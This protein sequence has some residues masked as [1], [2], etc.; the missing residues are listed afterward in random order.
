[1]SV[2]FKVP[3]IGNK[4]EKQKGPTCWFYAAKMIRKFHDAYDKMDGGSNIR[5]LSLVR[6]VITFMDEDLK[7]DEYGPQAPKSFQGMSAM[8][9]LPFT[10]PSD[11]FG[12]VL[13]RGFVRFAERS[14][15]SSATTPASPPVVIDLT[16]DTTD[17]LATGTATSVP[18]GP[19]TPNDYEAAFNL[20]LTWG[21]DSAFSRQAILDKWD[22]RPLKNLQI[23][24]ALQSPQEFEKLL[25][26]RGPI[27]AGG[28]FEPQTL[29]PL[30]PGTKQPF[31][32]GDKGGWARQFQL[33]T[34][35]ANTHAIAV[36]GVSD[37]QQLVL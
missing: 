31:V 26:E 19:P 2:F 24:N 28:F 11:P 7:S 21:R 6:K 25:I 32:H 29:L 15:P 35:F 1:M 22:F 34:D 10:E 3:S 17:P 20:M 37:K 14:T 5:L 33:K 4:S 27:W 36:L 12:L 13:Y 30:E 16:H 18:A 23:M 8:A 9:K